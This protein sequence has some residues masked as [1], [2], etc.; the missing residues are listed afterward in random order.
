MGKIVAVL[1]LTGLAVFGAQ[2]AYD[3]PLFDGGLGTAVSLE[4]AIPAT[5]TPPMMYAGVRG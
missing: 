5:A 4:S 2:L 1:A 3:A